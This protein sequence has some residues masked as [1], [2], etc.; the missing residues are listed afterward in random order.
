VNR[1]AF[2]LHLIIAFAFTNAAI[3]SMF[4]VINHADISKLTFDIDPHASSIRLNPVN[5]DGVLCLGDGGEKFLIFDEVNRECCVKHHLIDR[6]VHS[7]FHRDEGGLFIDVLVS[8]VLR[9][10]LDEVRNHE[11]DVGG[12]PQ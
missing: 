12:L 8:L 3:E 9:A 6:Q 1:L 5:H 2:S 7:F 11:H 10:V 4:A